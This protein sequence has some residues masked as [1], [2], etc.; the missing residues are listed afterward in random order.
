MAE[1]TLDAFND[2][3]FSNATMT[4]QVN[5]NIPFVPGFLG[6]LGV[7]T[8]EGVYTTTVA[9]DDENG[10]LSLIETS[11]RGAAPSQSKNSKG[12]TRHLSTVRL[13]REAVITA[14]QVSGVRV[15]GTANQLQTAERLV[16]KRVEGPTGLKAQL[17]FTLE[18]FYLGAIDGV[19]YDAD[20]TSVLWDYFAHYGQSRPGLTTWDFG[21]FTADG[22]EFGKACLKLRRAQTKAL[23]GFSLAGAAPVALCGDDFYDAAWGNKEV[24]QARQLAVTG[25]MQAPEIIAQHDAYDSFKYGGITW[26]NYRGSDD[27]KVAVPADEARLFA[28]GVPGLFKT[29]FAPA[30]TWDFVNTEGLPSYMLQ[31]EERQ[32]SSLR[33][34]EVQSNPLAICL[35]PKSLLRLKKA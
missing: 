23:N 12:T 2:D 19:V 7:F 20:G 24:T 35:R 28:M 3:A 31:R 6:S 27:T 18:H 21:A 4:A 17:G 29:Y 26:V 13:A 11:P 1:L 33:T 8:G 5:T 34:F 14:D 30:D 10:N 9:F 16:Y 25:N 15:L 22:S 32:T